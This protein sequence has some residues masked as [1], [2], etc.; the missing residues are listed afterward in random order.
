MTDKLSKTPQQTAATSTDKLFS[1]TAVSDK[2]RTTKRKKDKKR[3]TTTNARTTLTSTGS[4]TS[5]S[6]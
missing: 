5:I 3:P 6:L 1:L 4:Y 2:R